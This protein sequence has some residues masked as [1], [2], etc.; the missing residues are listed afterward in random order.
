MELPRRRQQREGTWKSA[1][2]LVELHCR[3]SPDCLPYAD[4]HIKTIR[5]FFFD[6]LDGPEEKASSFLLY[7]LPS[8]FPSFLLPSLFLFFLFLLMKKKASSSSPCSIT[9]K[10]SPWVNKSCPHTQ[11]F[12]TIFKRLTLKYE[13]CQG[14]QMTEGNL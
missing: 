7:F 4:R 10:W 3:L 11:G 6:K 14:S 1:K 2:E 13:Q 5:R 9:P 8:F 12:Q